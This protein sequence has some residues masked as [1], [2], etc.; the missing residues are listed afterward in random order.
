MTFAGII[1]I[2]RASESCISVTLEL[3]QSAC[4]RDAL[5][6][7]NHDARD[8]PRLTS[9]MSQQTSLVTCCSDMG[10]ETEIMMTEIQVRQPPK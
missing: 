4:D 9:S 3:D 2:F 1:L 5:A 8:R 7:S 6:A 10:A